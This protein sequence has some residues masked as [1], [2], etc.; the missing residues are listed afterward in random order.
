MNEKVSNELEAI[1]TRALES[2]LEKR[3]PSADEML[4]D[5]IRVAGEASSAVRACPHCREK[6]SRGRQ[7]CPH[8]RNYIAAHHTSTSAQIYRAATSSLNG[9]APATRSP[10]KI[11]RAWWI[12][13]AVIGA[14]AIIALG[15]WSAG[16]PVGR[17]GP[18]GSLQTPRGG[19]P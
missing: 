14:L 3:F 12:A 15:V 11:G 1:V 2:D 6:I 8:C 16:S 5:L 9:I 18:P 10:V 19:Q 13:A 4:I 17:S 7:F